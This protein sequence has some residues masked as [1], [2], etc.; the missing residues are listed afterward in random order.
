MKV[1]LGGMEEVEEE[2]TVHQQEIIISPSLSEMR[3][4][5]QNTHLLHLFGYEGVGG[6]WEGGSAADGWRC[7]QMRVTL[8]SGGARHTFPTIKEPA[9]WIEAP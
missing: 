6:G 8:L 3:A 9:A 7:L 1:G 5:Y 2:E 4:N